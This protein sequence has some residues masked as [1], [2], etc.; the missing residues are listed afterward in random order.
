MWFNKKK[1]KQLRINYLV[2]NLEGEQAEYKELKNLQ[3]FSDVTVS[4][5]AHLKGSIARIEAKLDQIRNGG[6]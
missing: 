5:M 1:E 3:H 6:E 2:M 4:R